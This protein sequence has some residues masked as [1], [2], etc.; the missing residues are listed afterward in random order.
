VLRRSRGHGWEHT[1]KIERLADPEPGVGYPRL[2][3]VNGRCPPEDS[4]GPW[5]YAELLQAIADP[6]HERH[7][8]FSDWLPNDFNPNIVDAD[9]L[10]EEVAALAKRWSRKPA[11]KRARRA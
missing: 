10:T 9:G 5:G 7:A 1:I 8:E 3:D 4:G 11:A 2:I 6:N